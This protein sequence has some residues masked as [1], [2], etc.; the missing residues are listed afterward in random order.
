M[1]KGLILAL[2]AAVG[3]AL[4]IILVR[5]GTYHAGESFTAT[6]VSI[7]TGVIF[8]AFLVLITGDWENLLI[9]EWS[10][11]LRLGG[12]GVLHYVLGRSLSYTS[13]RLI[14]ANRTSTILRTQILYPLVLGITVLHEPLTV[15]LII[16]V[17]CVAI[18]A[19]LVS[20][21]RS[22][23]DVS[24]ED[25]SSLTKGVLVCLAGALCWGLS[26]VII[27][28]IVQQIGTPF[29]AGLISYIA[30][31]LIMTGFLFIKSQREQLTRLKHDVLII[32]ILAGF[33]AAIA[34]L[35]RFSALI[36]SPV[37]I[38]EPII[39]ISG[40]FVFLFSFM[41][42]RKIEVFTWRVFMGIV[43]A[44]AGAFLFFQ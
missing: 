2:F 14:G 32:I 9:L 26:G 19:T 3:F 44:S 15:F 4:T 17:L 5:K 34:Q 23:K 1:E 41:I 6:F 16:G 30:A 36:Y 20:M 31:S 21:E 13:I 40:V 25:R 10:E 39:G 42:N 43:L 37:S 7:F 29:A 18:G 27:K 11:F 24:M 22:K 38:V 35:L 8:F 12:A 33:L 28:P